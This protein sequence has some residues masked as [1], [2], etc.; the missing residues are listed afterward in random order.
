MEV[1][2]GRVLSPF[3]VADYCYSKGVVTGYVPCRT[4]STESWC[5]YVVSSEGIVKCGGDWVWVAFRR[6]G[7]YSVL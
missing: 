7:V 2:F 6:C 5:R 1:E 4:R 3:T